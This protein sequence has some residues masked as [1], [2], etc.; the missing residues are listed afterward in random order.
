M[1]ITQTGKDKIARS[2]NKNKNL[3]SLRSFGRANNARPFYGRYEA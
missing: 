3:H 1:V 2:P